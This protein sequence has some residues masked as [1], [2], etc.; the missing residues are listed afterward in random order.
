MAERECGIQPPPVWAR[1]AVDKS[2]KLSEP[3]SLRLE[4]GGPGAP[5]WQMAGNYLG[6]CQDRAQPRACPWRTPAVSTLTVALM[7]SSDLLTPHTEAL[8][9]WLRPSLQP[10]LAQA[11]RREPFGLGL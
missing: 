5:T 6:K 8:P 1:V 3:Q 11:R 7:S 10:Q 4:N 2:G 9:P